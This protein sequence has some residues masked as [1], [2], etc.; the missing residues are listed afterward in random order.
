MG[1]GSS[2]TSSVR[3]AGGSFSR[4]GTSTRPIP[5]N[6]NVSSLSSRYETSVSPTS[7]YGAG[8]SSSVHQR[9]YTL[10]TSKTS[11]TTTPSSTS[12]S[13][14]SRQRADKSA[15][16]TSYSSP[17]YVPSNRYRS[18]SD[19]S[20]TATR[21]S[22]ASSKYSVSP[23]ASPSTSSRYLSRTTSTA[24]PL[25]TTF[26]NLS[27]SERSPSR[28]RRSKVEEAE[29]PK[30][31]R[32]VRSRRNSSS[33]RHTTTSSTSSLSNKS[34]AHES[35]GLRNLGNTCFM[36]SIIQCLVGTDVLRELFASGAYRSKLVKSHGVASAFGDLVEEF[37]R[38][39]SS[40]SYVSPSDLKRQVE[41]RAPQ[42]SGYSQH[43]S[44]ELLLF[45]LD[46]IHEDMNSCNR[47]KHPYVAL[48]KLPFMEQ[49][50]ES[51]KQYTLRDY[52]KLVE[53]FV[54][55]CVSTLTCLTCD[56]QSTVFEFF[57][58]I[59]VPLGSSVESCLTKFT[60]EEVMDGDEKPF[61]E[62]CKKRR[63]MRKHYQLW[64]LPEI[65]I[66][67][68]KRFRGEGSRYRS[69][70]AS[71][72]QLNTTIDV[73]KY[74]H[75]RGDRTQKSSY[76]LYAVSNHSGSTGGGHYTASCRNVD[77]SWRYC[78]DTRVS[79]MPAS[80]VQTSDAYVLF[81]KRI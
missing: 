65:L 49:A 43:D 78:N 25:T 36:N 70:D 28:S 1:A 32:G 40:S 16:S 54:G 81:Y 52:S 4:T 48:D 75:E 7:K 24:R 15:L 79:S 63:K 30:V 41:K 22:R 51:W 27:V 53:I 39:S 12:T 14:Y 17:S 45:L 23:P 69:K 64:R 42:F 5:I 38:K 29:A 80:Q 2:I 60:K 20:T 72:V 21:Q 71:N 55:Q 50:S 34:T 76:E 61:C 77:G 57:W 6:G 9:Y 62:S 18:A 44:Q 58:D 26:S 67:H 31:S 47:S 19:Q 33:K 74:L 3:V 66:I 10:P 56:E 37:T 46:G 35:V 8:S 59:S 68:L 11:L 73:A 13:L